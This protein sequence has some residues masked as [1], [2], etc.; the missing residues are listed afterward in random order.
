MLEKFSQAADRLATSVS[1]RSFLNQLGRT[2]IAVASLLGL[3]VATG[4]A[5]AARK[6]KCCVYRLLP[7]GGTFTTCTTG[8]CPKE[9]GGSGYPLVDHFSV[10]DCFD[11][12]GSLP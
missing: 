4:H 11:C 7:F 9:Y 10:S 2:G 1:R 5:Q 3:V 6:F 8:G 12:T